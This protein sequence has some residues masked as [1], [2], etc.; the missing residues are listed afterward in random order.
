MEVQEVGERAY[1]KIWKREEIKSKTKISKPLPFLLLYIPHFQVTDE[2]SRGT[3]E[4]LM[5]PLW[6]SIYRLV[7]VW[8]VVW[9]ERFLCI[10]FTS[11]SSGVLPKA[12]FTFCYDPSIPE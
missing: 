2:K 12:A 7:F 9:A 8:P 5:N 11:P 4:F 3:S 1:D 6:A 10:Y